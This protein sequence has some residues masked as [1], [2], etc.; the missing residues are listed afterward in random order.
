MNTHQNTPRKIR[1]DKRY[2]CLEFGWLYCAKILRKI[3]MLYDL[4]Q[5]YAR[6]Q[7]YFPSTFEFR[8]MHINSIQMPAF[9]SFSRLTF[10][11]TLQFWNQKK[12][13]Q[14]YAHEMWFF[15]HILTY[16]HDECSKDKRN[17]CTPHPFTWERQVSL[18]KW[19]FYA[20][21]PS[22][23]H[24]FKDFGGKYKN[25]IEKYT[26]TRTQNT[27]RPLVVKKLH[28]RVLKEDACGV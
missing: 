8:C 25:K 18:I 20:I 9:V 10:L 17:L 3:I 1:T 12:Q 11:C 4:M 28:T 13:Q 19:W 27:W 26:I 23:P 2:G 16:F 21:P 7:H 24:F 22:L 5:I 6:C 15:M 14:N